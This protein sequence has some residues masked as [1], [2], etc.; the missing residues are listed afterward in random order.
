M[1]LSYRFISFVS[2]IFPVSPFISK[3]LTSFPAQLAHSSRPWGRGWSSLHVVRRSYPSLHSYQNQWHPVRLPGSSRTPLLFLSQELAGP[4][5]SAERA[6][7]LPA[8][9]HHARARGR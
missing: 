9:L 8:Q 3:I 6:A 1:I 4:A 5:H 7:R 2:R